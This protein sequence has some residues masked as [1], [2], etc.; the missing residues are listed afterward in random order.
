VVCY[1][2]ISVLCTL[3]L[4]LK[5]AR[6][7]FGL[8]LTPSLHCLRTTH[9]T[10]AQLSR[11]PDPHVPWTFAGL[12]LLR[13][14]SKSRGRSA[15]QQQQVFSYRSTLGLGGVGS[16]ALAVL[17]FLLNCTRVC[18]RLLHTILSLLTK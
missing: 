5:A 1:R 9:P 15:Q 6:L 7:S 16:G 3:Y 18:S 12:L 14:C 10:P 11:T 2:P 17:G 8:P 4:R 13:C